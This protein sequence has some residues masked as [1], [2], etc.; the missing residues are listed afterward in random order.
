MNV[1]YKATFAKDLGS[2]NDKGL[3]GRIKRAIE[4]VEKAQTLQ[5]ITNLGKLKGGKTYYRI[6]VGEYRIG[7]VIEGST[8]TF[9]R[10]LNRKDIY[11]RF[12]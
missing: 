6:R 1:K 7:L 3:L 2:V 11:S 12:P 10:C 4:Q 8:V 5:D 9:V